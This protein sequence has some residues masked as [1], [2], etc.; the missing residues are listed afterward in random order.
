VF[1]HG[2]RTVPQQARGR[3]KGSARG[4][5]AWFW[6]ISLWPLWHGLRLG[7]PFER[8][9]MVITHVDAKPGE[10]GRTCEMVLQW[11]AAR[12]RHVAAGQPRRRIGCS[13]STHRLR[14]GAADTADRRNS[15]ARWTGPS[16]QL[17]WNRWAGGVGSG[18]VTDPAAHHVGI[19]GAGEV[20]RDL[21]V[22]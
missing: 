1:S 2:G 21:K 4:R 16:R 10:T 3:K 8:W 15:R 18:P 22:G 19:E 13:T 17:A 12:V 20:C 9:F 6:W 14:C 11:D 5:W 7:W